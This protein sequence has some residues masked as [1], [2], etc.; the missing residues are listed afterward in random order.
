MP[1]ISVLVPVRNAAPWLTAALRSLWRQTFTDFE[2]IAVNDGSS[3]DSGERLER[4]AREEPRLRVVHT[5]ARGLPSA[6]NTALGLARGRLVARQ[7]ADDLSHRRRF[8]RQR[9]HLEAHRGVAVVG[10][11]LRL[12][13]ATAIGAGMRRW[14]RWHNALLTHEAM[15]HEAL[16]DSPLA[17][18]T[19]MIRRTALER[20][21]GWRDRG[22]PED[23]DLWLRM[24]EAGA[25]FA[26]LP[27][28][29]Y[30]WRR[31]PGSATHRDPRYRRERYMDLR[32]EALERGLLAGARRV[33][34]VGVGARLA[35]W[36]APRA[37]RVRTVDVLAGNHPPTG[38]MDIEPPIVLVFGAPEARRRWRT[39]LARRGLS[40]GSTFVFVA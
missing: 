7:D 21:G 13:P 12:F 5:A 11:R 9:A 27:D 20:V 40:E 35:V 25:R 23:V 22:W 30:G 1:S 2:V 15:A 28:T 17:H 37:A 38:D 31:H 10:C 16:I 14:A 36:R 26:K 8:A 3:D 6:L 19:A 29:L 34:L 39:T 4:A 33:T 18:G 24:L 32:L